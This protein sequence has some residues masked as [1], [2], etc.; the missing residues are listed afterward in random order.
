MVFRFFRDQLTVLVAPGVDAE[1]NNSYDEL[2]QTRA[3]SKLN[4]EVISNIRNECVLY[5]LTVAHLKTSVDLFYKCERV[6]GT[7]RWE[8]RPWTS[9]ITEELQI[10]RGLRKWYLRFLKDPHN[11][12]KILNVTYMSS[13][14]PCQSWHKNSFMKKNKTYTLTVVEVTWKK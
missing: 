12:F 13:Y 2:P 6:T 5:K 4:R 7:T 10:C 3:R 8:R 9:A 14:S 1:V 11:G